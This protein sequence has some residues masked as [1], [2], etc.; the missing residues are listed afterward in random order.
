MKD[1]LIARIRRSLFD[2]EVIR[3]AGMTLLARPIGI[4]NQMLMAN[5]FGAGMM[6]DAYT[7]A[8]SL[9]SFINTIIGQVYTAAIIPLSIEY[10]TI[11]GRREQLA[12]QNAAIL[13]FQIFVI[14]FLL[15][16]IFGGELLVTS[17]FPKTPPETSTHAIRMLRILAVPGVLIQLVALLRAVLNLNRRFRVAGVIPIVHG[18]ITL[19]TIIALQGSHGI[20]CLPISVAISFVAQTTILA[21]DA[22]R[23]GYLAFVKPIFP[24]GAM[25]RVWS[26]GS[27]VL[28]AQIIL[29]VNRFVDKGF[30]T[31][32][33]TGSLSSIA[34]INVLMTMIQLLV[35][36]SL[37]VV[38]FTNISEMIS[39]RQMEKCG[40]YVQSNLQNL[41]RLVIPTALALVVASDEIVR[42]LFERGEFDAEDALR[43]STALSFYMLGIPAMVINGVIGRI[44]HALQRMKDR[45][46]LALQ[47]LVTNTVGSL[48]LVHQM[49]LRGLAISAA[50][51]ITVH[52]ALSIFILHRYRTGMDLVAVARSIGRDYLLGALTLAGYHLVPKTSWLEP[53][54]QYGP[55]GTFAVLAVKALLVFVLFGSL[56]FAT[57][58]I[59]R[60]QRQ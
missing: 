44:F 60:R 4:A 56:Y 11:L 45:V 49:Q 35:A 7:L 6:Y 20:W 59:R 53:L 34:Y 3:L 37:V 36:R 57:N 22:L 23:N 2:G 24:P 54:L 9:V 21:I 33:E 41:T 46:W 32:L 48:L 52:V 26:L 47:Y 42:L 27:S 55:A 39:N 43:T 10:R 29:T 1:R 14:A 58:S 15:G 19:V 38:M 16:L 25:A 31:G 51:A 18:G 8:F 12:F 40:R 5:Y 28:L 50:T 13:F 17:L 30:A